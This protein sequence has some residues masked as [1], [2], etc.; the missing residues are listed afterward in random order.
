MDLPCPAGFVVDDRLASCESVHVYIHQINQGWDIVMDDVQISTISTKEPSLTP[1]FTPTE[2]TPDVTNSPTTHPTSLPTVTSITSCPDAETASIIVSAGPIML[3]KSDLLCILTKAVQQSDG[4]LSNIAPVARSY[5][6]RAWEPSAGDFAERLLHNTEFGDY[7]TGTQLNLPE[8]SAGEKYYLTSYSY[9]I[10]EE[11]EVA[12]LLESAT[13]GTRA[14][15]LLSWNKGIAT[16]DAASQWIQEQINKPMTSHRDFFRRRVNPRFPNPRS[17][18]RSDHPCNSLT[19]WRAFTFSNKDGDLWWHRQSLIASFKEGDV[20]VTI[21]LNGHLRT[22]VPP[23]SIVFDNQDYMFEYNT[24]YQM[25][26]RPEE[27]SGGRVY[28]RMEDESCQWFKNPLIAFHPDSIQPSKIL[29]LPNI[30]Q[31]IFQ[32]IDEARSN[33]EEFILFNGINHTSCDQ[34]N[35]VTELN[36]APV[37]GKV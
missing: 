14:E 4:T 36:D 13:F 25:C 15:D 37:F 17:I 2:Y 33:S 20:H 9:D 23:G 3:A 29:N 5:D 26:H 19:R 6:G 34:L 11:S 10:D 18:G 21:K 1:T 28:L 8:L 30:T 12:R 32:S 7:N 24:E 16:A 22:V 27:K 31:T 35:D